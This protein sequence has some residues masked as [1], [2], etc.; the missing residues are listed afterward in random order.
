MPA[1]TDDTCPSQ[2]RDRHGWR[3]GVLFSASADLLVAW[4][5]ASA[6]MHRR[7]WGTANRRF[8]ALVRRVRQAR[9]GGDV[10]GI[11][12]ACR[13]LLHHAEARPVRA[14]LIRD[15]FTQLRRT[16]AWVAEDVCLIGCDTCQDPG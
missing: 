4:Y 9:L 15:A 1:D 12:Q 7:T 3:H 14:P 5:A 6:G 10:D 13:A 8:G 11:E 16:L 2:I